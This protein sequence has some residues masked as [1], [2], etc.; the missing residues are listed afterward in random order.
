MKTIVSLLLIFLIFFNLSI[1]AE[2]N[3]NHKIPRFVSTKFNESNLRIGASIDY[4]IKLT[5]FVEN[6]PLKIIGEYELWREVV[7]I[8]G[9]QGWMKKNLLKNKRYGIIKTTHTQQAQI[10]NKPKGYIIGKIGNR[11]IVKIKK[12]F[13]IWCEVKFNH[14]SGWINKSNIWGVDDKEEFNL[15]FYHLL[16]VLYWKIK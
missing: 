1:T 6:F 12:C 2:E 11:N 10:Y 9:N 8:D 5:Y 3:I 14:H 13:K 7:D 15:P 4:P 16:Y